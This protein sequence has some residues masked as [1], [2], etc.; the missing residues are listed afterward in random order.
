MKIENISIFGEYKQAENR[1]TAAFLQI[2]KVGG[3]EFIRFLTNQLNIQ[4]PSS[5]IE[6]QSQVKGEGSV[7][8]GL[9]ESNFSFR[10]FVE[11][12]IKPNS[13]NLAQLSGHR[14]QIVS[15]HDFLLYLTPDNEKPSIL[16]KTQ[17]A[18]WL[19]IINAFNDYLQTSQTE[20]KQLLEFLVGHFNTL[21]DN[22]NLLGYTWDLS[23][24]SVIVLAGSWAEGIALNF[25]YYICQNRRSF[26]PSRYLAFYNSNQI[27][28]VFEIIRPPEDDVNI[29]ERQEFEVL[30]QQAPYDYT[31][32]VNK[33]FTLKLAQD[34]GPIINDKIDKNG[35]PC[36]FTY[37]QPRYTTLR[38][39]LSST[40]TSQL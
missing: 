39:L 22:L 17:W 35:N 32:S 24:E 36:P 21:L 15:K 23:N 28:H 2:C 3:E 33:V 11:S 5:E 13:V 20:N 30:I 40:R 38:A 19:Q 31:N 26:K 29:S 4:L 16:G 18:N 7:P 37:G 14:K 25:N 9:L 1:V 10:L 8:D 27:R 6:I 12:K 34:V